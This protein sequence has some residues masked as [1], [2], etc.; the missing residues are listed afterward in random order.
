MLP[1]N[2]KS[3]F[4][5]GKLSFS[6]SASNKSILFATSVSWANVILA[7]SRPIAQ[8]RTVAF[9][10]GYFLQ[11]STQYKP[12]EPPISNILFGDPDNVRRDTTSFTVLS[13]S[14]RIAT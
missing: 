2:I 3:Y 5:E 6:K 8:S 7:F 14:Q 9:K 10:P 13:P 12:C 11:N 4:S 1:R